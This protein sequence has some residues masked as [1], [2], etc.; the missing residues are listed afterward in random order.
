MIRTGIVAEQA[1][2]P[3]PEHDRVLAP[4]QVGEGPVVAAVDA[5]GSALARGAPCRALPGAE[6]QGDRGSGGLMRPGFE[7]DRSRIR[8][9][10]GE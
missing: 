8:Q 2:H 5:A 9:Q 6:G 7:P 3:Q 1:A 4:G 10:A